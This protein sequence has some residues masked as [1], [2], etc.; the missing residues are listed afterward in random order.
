VA[1][2]RTTTSSSRKPR[3][4]SRAASRPSTLPPPDVEPED[5]FVEP[6]V[7]A[8]EAQEI[9]VEGHYVTAELCGEELRITPPGGW[10]LSLQRLL[11]AGQIDAFAQRVLH[12]DD[13]D[14][15]FE[16]DPTSDEFQQFVADAGAQAGE[17]LG[18]SRGPA[19]SLRRTRR[20]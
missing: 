11:N 2:T 20:R 4:A 9:E 19:P 1:N 18:N 8:A 13:V 14:L 3:T 5:D 17:G 16:L 12:P 6:E 15:F 10:R 7:S